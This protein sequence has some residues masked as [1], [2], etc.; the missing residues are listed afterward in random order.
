ML[1]AEYLSG[2]IIN[3][4]EDD[5]IESIKE[6][7]LFCPGCKGEVVLKNGN[8]RARHFAHKSLK[9][10]EFYSENESQE[11]LQLKMDL[12]KWLNYDTYAQVEYY[13]PEIM[14]IAD[15]M[16]ELNIALEVQC[17]SLSL[18][19]LSERTLS[20]KKIG[21]SVLWLLG[22]KLHLDKK[23]NKLN[24]NFLYFSMNCGFYYWELCNKQKCLVLKY[25]IHEDLKGNLIYKEKIFPFF[26]GNLLDILR[27]PYRKQKSEVI[28]GKKISDMELYISQNLRRKNG[29]WMEIAGLYYQKG[30]SL[31][32]IKNYPVQYFPLGFN[33]YRWLINESDHSSFLQINRDLSHYYENF[34]KYYKLRDKSGRQLMYP[35]A[36]YGKM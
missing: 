31:R 12:Y 17:S 25:L 4:L 6:R 20:Y 7:K 27:F 13:L 10:C 28:E 23:V 3:L 1:T 11:H 34:I 32:D 15:I 8:I 19:R 35:P 33:Y 16:V 26:K 36:F 5:N 14:Q 30:L 29:K 22:K 21:C 18:K 2:K 9:N 24:M